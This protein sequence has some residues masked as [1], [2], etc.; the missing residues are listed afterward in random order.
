MVSTGVV[1][2]SSEQNLISLLAVWI[3]VPSAL[4]AA[5]PIVRGAMLMVPIRLLRSV[6]NTALIPKRLTR[7]MRFAF[8]LLWLASNLKAKRP[9]MITLSVW[10]SLLTL[11][12]KSL[13]RMTNLTVRTDLVS[14]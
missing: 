12:P 3:Q 8:P 13:W 5:S 14:S 11:V 6:L 10:I 4:Q 1:Q 7:R 9:L 2:A